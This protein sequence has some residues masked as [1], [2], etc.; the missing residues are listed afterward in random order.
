MWFSERSTPLG[1]FLIWA[2]LLLAQ[3]AQSIQLDLDSHGQ[4]S[5]PEALFN[6]TYL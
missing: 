1:C 6:L 2:T 5:L 3:I 4:T